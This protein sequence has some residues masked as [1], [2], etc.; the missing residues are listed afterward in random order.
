MLLRDQKHMS[1]TWH[2]RRW[3]TL[4]QAAAVVLLVALVWFLIAS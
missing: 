1:S 2:P 4:G 3:D